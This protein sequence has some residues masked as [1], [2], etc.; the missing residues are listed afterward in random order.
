MVGL[1]NPGAKYRMTR[2]NAGF[3]V[4]DR[5]AGDLGLNWRQNKPFQAE[6]CTGRHGAVSLI[7]AKPQTYMNLSGIAVGALAKYYDIPPNRIIV[8]AD[9]LALNPGALRIRSRGSSGGHN[10]LKSIISTVGDGFIRVRV[11]VGHPGDS[12]EVVDYVLQRFNAVEWEK[13]QDAVERSVQAILV[14]LNDGVES[15]MNQFNRRAAME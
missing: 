5:L 9:D 11:G 4:L 1:G 3:L 15:A 10:G 8:V 2:H 7:L 6:T 14:I 12:E 13:V